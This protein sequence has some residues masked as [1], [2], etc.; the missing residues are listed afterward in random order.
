MIIN[1]RPLTEIP[2]DPHEKE[3]LT[4]NHFVLGDSGGMQIM[5]V[6]QSSD[7]LYK[8]WKQSQYLAEQFCRW[9][10]REYLPFLT[11]RSKWHQKTVPIKI[12]NI[13]IVVDDRHPR[14]YWKKGIIIDVNKDKSG[15]G[16]SAVVQTANG[17][18]TRPTVKLAVLDVLDKNNNFTDGQII[19]VQDVERTRPHWVSTQKRYQRKKRRGSKSS[20]SNYSWLK[21]V[22]KKT[23]EILN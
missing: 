23:I 10:I 21:F 19:G 2:V 14:N 11:R 18:Y 5:G 17:A 22:I 6:C 9:W 8:S 3:A 4:P 7:N 12:G 15:W 20:T 1:S 13:V 16:K